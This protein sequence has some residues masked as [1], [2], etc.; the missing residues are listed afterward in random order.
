M[1]KKKQRTHPCRHIPKCA[2]KTFGG[3]WELFTE[4][5]SEGVREGSFYFFISPSELLGF[6]HELI[7]LS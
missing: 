5:I 2:E 3:Y 7:F 1:L 4:V 6:H